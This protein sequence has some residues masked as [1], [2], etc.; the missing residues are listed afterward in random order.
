MTRASR[1][2]SQPGCPEIIPSGGS[3]PDHPARAPWAGRGSRQERGYDAEFERNRKVVLDEE[4]HC[5]RCGGLGYGDDQVGHKMA[6]AAG[7]TSARENLQREH[8]LCNQREG[9]ARGGRAAR[10]A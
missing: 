8:K 6:P 2:C 1:I 5:A 4:T 7:G 9:A 10:R 3:C